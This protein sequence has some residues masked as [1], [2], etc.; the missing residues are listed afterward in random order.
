MTDFDE[1][2]QERKERSLRKRLNERFKH[3]CHEAEK[4]A[5]E[6]NNSVI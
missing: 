2:E 3:F 6:V 5:M 1:L 4:F